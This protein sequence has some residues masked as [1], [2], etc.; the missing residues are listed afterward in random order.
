MVRLGKKEEGPFKAKRI[1]DTL[2]TKAD[3]I[4]TSDGKPFMLLIH[5]S[6]DNARKIGLGANIAPTLFMGAHGEYE[7]EAKYNTLGFYWPQNVPGGQFNQ[8]IS[9]QVIDLMAKAG[10]ILPKAVPFKQ[11]EEEQTIPIS[12]EGTIKLDKDGYA[13][14]SGSFTISKPRGLK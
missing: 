1:L 11:I 7:T 5:L 4:F 10:T 12:R 9:G 14:F 8:N 3:S 6:E 2:E 13:T